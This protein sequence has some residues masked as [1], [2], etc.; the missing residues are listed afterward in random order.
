MGVIGRHDGS[1]AQHWPA[2]VSSVHTFSRSIPINDTL[3]TRIEVTTIFL[4]LTAHSSVSALVGHNL[5]LIASRQFQQV[6]G[7]HW[8]LLQIL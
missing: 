7:L 4:G 1:V 5:V 8:G 6:E 3:I 2:P